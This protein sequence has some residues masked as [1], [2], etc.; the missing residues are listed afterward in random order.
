MKVSEFREVLKEVP[1][2]YEALFLFPASLGLPHGGHSNTVDVEVRE[3]D[4]A[5]YFQG[6]FH[7][8]ADP[9]PDLNVRRI[10]HYVPDLG[11]NSEVDNG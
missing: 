10:K 5:V 7:P 2:D 11:D 4:R 3:A 8:G 9:R 6:F 1:Q